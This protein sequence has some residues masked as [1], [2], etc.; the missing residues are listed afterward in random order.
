MTAAEAIK[1]SVPG[2]E[3]VFNKVPKEWAHSDIYGK[4]IPNKDEAQPY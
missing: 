1:K 2:C 3:V 4:I